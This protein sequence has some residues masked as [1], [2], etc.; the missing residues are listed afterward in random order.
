M[1]AYGEFRCG[2]NRDTI[3]TRIV[4][5]GI[6]FLIEHYINIRWT[7][8]D[9]LLAEKFIQTHNAGFTPFPFPKDLFLKVLMFEINFANKIWHISNDFKYF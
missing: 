5:Y 1:V 9:V 7:V 2:Y 4:C 8:E 3:D 6:R